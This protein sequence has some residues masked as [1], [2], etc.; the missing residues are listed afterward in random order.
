MHGQFTDGTAGKEQWSH[1][2]RVGRKGEPLP[3]DREDCRV[4][5]AG[6]MI[7][8][9]LRQKQVFDQFAG[10]LAT[11]SVPQGD[12]GVVSEAARDRRSFR[13][14]AAWWEVGWS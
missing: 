4:A 9:E 3:A 2:E 12:V 8:L 14:K 11:S 10:E 6:E 1:D 13:E 5:Q 7:V